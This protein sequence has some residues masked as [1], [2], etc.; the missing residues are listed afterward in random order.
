[1]ANNA[2]NGHFGF[3]KESFK[4]FLESFLSLLC[5]RRRRLPWSDPGLRCPTYVILSNLKDRLKVN[6]WY[7]LSRET[8]FRFIKL[9]R[10]FIL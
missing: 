7:V 3:Q 5:C 4:T 2:L 6:G 9:S 8:G 1:V 10:G